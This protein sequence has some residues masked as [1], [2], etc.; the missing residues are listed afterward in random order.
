VGARTIVAMP[1]ARA[2]PQDTVRLVPG[3]TADIVPAI[4]PRSV[5][6]STLVS[7]P[8]VGYFWWYWQATR[9]VARL[10]DEEL[11]AWFWL[12]MVFPGMLL[13]VPYVYAQVKLVARVEVATREPLSQMA[14]LLTCLGGVI[15]PG[16]LPLVLQPR[17]NR[18][19]RVDAEELRRRPLPA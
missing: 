6:F 16:L 1:G 15:V 19:A 9:D 7:L 5:A 4:A 11:D 13:V 17:L 2:R 10:L 3:A 14:Y 12:C 8:I 18:A